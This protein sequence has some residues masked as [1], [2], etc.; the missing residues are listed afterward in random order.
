MNS[1]KSK[2]MGKGTSKQSYYKKWKWLDFRYKGQFTANCP[3]F[4]QVLE[5]L[6]NLLNEGL[7]YSSLNSS[8]CPF[9]NTPLN[10]LDSLL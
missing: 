3:S 9:I 1:S 7:C 2:V 8:L 4:G 10:R 5:V 6:L